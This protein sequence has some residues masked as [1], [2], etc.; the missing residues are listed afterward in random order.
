MNK[1]MN[2]YIEMFPKSTSEKYKSCTADY[3]LSSYTLTHISENG[4]K[5]I[6]FNGFTSQDSLG[7]HKTYSYMFENE[8]YGDKPINEQLNESTE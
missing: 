2:D 4:W 8:N 6:S 3:E 7:N 5:L 1:T